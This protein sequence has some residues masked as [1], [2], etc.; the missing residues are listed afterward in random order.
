MHHE[1]RDLSHKSIDVVNTLNDAAKDSLEITIGQ[2]C[3]EQ[4][5]IINHASTACEEMK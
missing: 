4:N 2:K 3:L 1:I 5:V